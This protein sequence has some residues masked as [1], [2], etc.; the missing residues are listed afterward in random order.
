MVPGNLVTVIY[1]KF[2]S[3]SSEIKKRGKK[4]VINKMGEKNL[5]YGDEW[6]NYQLTN[7]QQL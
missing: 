2:A 3:P 7:Y 6:A 1:S 4:N 5:Q